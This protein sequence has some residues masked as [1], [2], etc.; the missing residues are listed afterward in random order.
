[1]GAATAGIGWQR[2]HLRAAVNDWRRKWPATKEMMAAIDN[3]V[4]RGLTV[5]MDGINSGGSGG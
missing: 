3:C 5:V 4:P 2:Y 1:M